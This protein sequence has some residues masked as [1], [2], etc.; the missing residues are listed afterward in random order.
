MVAGCPGGRD[1]SYD[2]FG[3]LSMVIQEVLLS[4]LRLAGDI[5]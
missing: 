5:C 4:M 1:P 3:P 2:L